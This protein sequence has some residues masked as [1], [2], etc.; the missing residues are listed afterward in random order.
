MLLS[1][2]RSFYKDA[3]FLKDELRE[4]FNQETRVRRHHDDRLMLLS[5]PRHHRHHRY[6]YRRRR[7]YIANG[8]LLSSERRRRQQQHPNS[9]TVTN[10]DQLVPLSRHS[11]SNREASRIDLPGKCS[12]E[13]LP[14]GQEVFSRRNWPHHTDREGSVETPRGV[15][16]RFRLLFIGEGLSGC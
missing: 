1:A 4:D 3:T 15:L 12:R 5:L 10:V 7:I 13:S 11:D 2:G 8:F 6:R 9:I 14:G 16:L